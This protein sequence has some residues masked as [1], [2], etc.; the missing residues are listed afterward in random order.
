M[1]SRILS[2]IPEH[3]P[4]AVR[5]LR[6]MALWWSIFACILVVAGIE[7]AIYWHKG[8]RYVPVQTLDHVWFHDVSVQSTGS[9]AVAIV[10]YKRKSKDQA[11]DTE[12]VTLDFDQHRARSIRVAGL[13]PLAVAIVPHPTAS[14]SQSL[15]VVDAD[16]SVHCVTESVGPSETHEVSVR[17]VCDSELREAS[18]VAF[19][20]DGSR[21]A[22][23]GDQYVFIWDWHE[24]KLLHRYRHFTGGGRGSTKAL[25][26][27]EDSRTLLAPGREGGLLSLDLRSGQVIEV[28]EP[29]NRFAFDADVSS[30]QQIMVVASSGAVPTLSAFRR[31]TEA[32]LWQRKVS[33]PIA[34][35]GPEG[36]YVASVLGG[37]GA[38]RV[39]TY[40]P[41]TGAELQSFQQHP[42]HIVGV[43]PCGKSLLSWDSDGNLFESDVESGGVK[44][45]FS[46][47]KWATES[48]HS[49]FDALPPPEPD[50]V[51]ISPLGSRS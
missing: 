24:A 3:P 42:S 16:G 1:M 6:F 51:E 12:I 9:V 43:A 40:D 47:L 31:G 35:F 22:A 48:N 46:L 34:A 4:L 49:G 36:S 18:R 14:R 37:I 39:A 8:F 41:Q 10:K 13:Q 28:T 26:F 23:I 21:L 50:R 7:A 44:W 20:P 15:A 30:D 19:S 33:A 5:A 2:P 17:K 29:E 45:S 38:Q 11:V 25:G 27:S 32:R